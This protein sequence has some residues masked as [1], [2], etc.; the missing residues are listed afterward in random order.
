VH[1]KPGRFVVNIETELR[2]TLPDCSNVSFLTWGKHTAT[3]EYQDCKHVILAGVLQYS[4]PQYQAV[5]R[6]AKK[7]TTG[8]ELTE[9]D[10]QSVRLGEIAHNI[11]HASCRGNVRKME[12]DSCPLDC[13]L[14]IVFSAY[15]EIGIPQRLLGVI[16]PGAAVI[17]WLPVPRVTGKKQRALV[18]R[19]K[20]EYLN[21]NMILKSA[22]FRS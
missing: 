14:Y 10:H 4:I 2:K 18:S 7:L 20:E 1:F 12:N 6:S 15:R 11:F 5:G 8:E 22:S 9:T 19:L 17:D 16:F 21:S 13:H 3:N